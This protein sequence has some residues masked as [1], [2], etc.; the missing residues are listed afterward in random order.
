VNVC[1]T[2]NGKR[3]AAEIAAGETLLDFLRAR[4]VYSVKRGCDHGECGTCT[5]LIDGKAVNACLILMFT[6]AGKTVETVEGLTPRDKLHPLQQRFLDAGA[7]QCG[8]CTPGML[9]AAEALLREHPDPSPAEIRD[10]LSGV[11][12]RCTGYVKPVE[13]VKP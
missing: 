4:G 9:L 2:L 1:F 10:A 12:C 7:I 6:I 11:L 8:Y 5:V 13:A 3:V